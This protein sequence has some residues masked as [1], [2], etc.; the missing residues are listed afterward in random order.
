MSARTVRMEAIP[1][2]PDFVHLSILP[3][4][5]ELRYATPANFAGRDLYSPYDCAWLHRE[6]AE[7]IATAAA[8]L[9][10]AGHGYRLLV[11]DALRPQRVQEALWEALAGTDLRV[12]LAEPTRGSIHSFGMAVD[13]TLIDANGVELDM[14]TAFD[15]LNERSHPAHES[16]LVA[17]GELTHRQVVNREAL[18]SV[19]TKGG[20]AGISTEWWHF[21][22]GNRERIR[23]EFA[24]VL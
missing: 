8:A 19:M 22:H 10:A 17:A 9:S 20:F 7:G 2:H 16:R 4:R 14:G 21:D 3:V 18:R 5:Y 6:A 24:R 23:S 13:V 12:Y 1:T 11:L 15:E